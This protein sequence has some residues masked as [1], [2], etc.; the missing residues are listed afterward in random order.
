MKKRR[1]RAKSDILIDLTSLLD[2]IFIVLLVVIGRQQTLTEKQQEQ[3]N[4]GNYVEEA[5]AQAEDARAK[6]ELYV[7]QLDTAEQLQNIVCAISVYC[8]FESNDVTERHVEI[9]RKGSD[10]AILT[11][12]LHGKG[13]DVDDAYSQFEKAL[14]DYVTANA[15]FP[16][17]LSLNENDEKILYRDQERIKGIFDDLMQEQDNVYVHRK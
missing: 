9:L 13:K 12:D 8:Y 4:A 1:H 11:F 17:I 2:V 3:M 10:K 16:V 6:Y 15:E 7:D 5:T 14:R